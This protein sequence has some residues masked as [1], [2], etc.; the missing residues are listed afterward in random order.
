M[1]CGWMT[2]LVYVQSETYTQQSFFCKAHG[3]STLLHSSWSNLLLDSLFKHSQMK[4]KGKDADILLASSPKL[5]TVT[6]P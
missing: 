2:G 3:S 5:S 6:L 4:L 1:V